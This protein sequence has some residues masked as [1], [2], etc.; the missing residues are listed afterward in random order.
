MCRGVRKLQEK[1]S[2]CQHVLEWSTDEVSE[3]LERKGYREYVY[4]LCNEHHINGKALLLLTEQDL[5]SPPLN[6]QVNMSILY[7][8]VKTIG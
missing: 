7:K 3:W 6:I 1:M 8:Q 4:L 5:R 2:S